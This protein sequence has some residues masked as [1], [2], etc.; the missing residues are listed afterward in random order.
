MA[1][2]ALSA[3]LVALSASA[4][5][6]SGRCASP[7][8]LSVEVTVCPGSGLEADE[9]RRSL[10]SELEADGVVR[11][12]QAGAGDGTLLAQVG[13]DAALTTRVVLSVARTGRAGQR[14][15]VLADAD[16]SA[17]ARV[18]AL[19][20]SEL[21]R[22]DW[23]ELNDDLPQT[24]ARAA[25]ADAPHPEETTPKPAQAAPV[26]PVA[27]APALAPSASVASPMPARDAGVPRRAPRSEAR[28]ALAANARLRWFV[29]YASFAVGGDLG[30]DWGPFRLRAELV[31]TSA[32]DALGSAT[33]GSGALCFGYRV[34]EHKLG[35]LSVSGYP[36]A[37][38]GVTWL[39]GT[40]A[41]SA[42][43][44]APAT[45]F[46]GDLRLAAEA[47]WTDAALSP[48]LAAEFGRATGFVARAS[49]R[50]LGA[51]G[52][53]FVGASAGGRY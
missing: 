41:S 44:S 30:P 28:W 5:A 19:A 16:P 20:A 43:Q 46:Y 10:S 27:P 15:L 7:S 17:R 18:L 23:P 51:T 22:S 33:L 32:E 53:F 37:S 6:R 38:A 36:L 49:D 45:G 39:R 12:A 3:L 52:G 13:C 47:R 31:M 35:P 14:S 8:T 26:A 1:R 25:Y 40:S 21:V 24:E 11:V 29:D 9:V 4:L 42:V 48:T 2:R 50:V 34:F